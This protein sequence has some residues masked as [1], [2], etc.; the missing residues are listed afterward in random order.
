M[1]DYDTLIRA[2]YR[3]IGL[4]SPTT[5]E[6]DDG[7]E[8]V[9]N[10]LSIWGLDYLF[11]YVTRESFTLTIGT[12]TYTIGSAGNFNTVRPIQISNVYLRD[13]SG[14]DDIDYPIDILSK[15]EYGDISLKGQSNRPTKLYYIPEYPLA[16][17]IFNYAPDKAYTI[18][19][20]FVKNFVEG[21]STATTVP[22]PNEY[23][24]PIVYNLAVMLAQNKK[25]RLDNTVLIMAERYKDLMDTMIA[26]LTTVPPVKIYGTGRL[27]IKTGDYDR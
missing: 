24:A 17:I 8:E 13:T 21:A 20:E 6:L 19:F 5:T 22:L 26:S 9:N 18:L 4:S 12:D 7:L 16:K 15:E 25:I 23:K 10:M 1:A 14:S 11:P 27:N 3:K 2:A